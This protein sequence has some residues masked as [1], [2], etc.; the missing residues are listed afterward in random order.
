MDLQFSKLYF[1]C[2]CEHSELITLS[3]LL[4]N[5]KLIWIINSYKRN[6]KGQCYLLSIKPKCEDENKSSINLL[7]LFCSLFW[8]YKCWSISQSFYYRYWFVFFF[9]FENDFFFVHK[10][11]HTLSPT[12]VHIKTH[13]P[14]HT[15]STKVRFSIAI[16]S[17]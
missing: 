5:Q 14:S 10:H 16:S 15:L 12:H 4:L 1:K 2:N 8:T 6:F 7:L 17:F 11:T 3:G 9:F 13:T